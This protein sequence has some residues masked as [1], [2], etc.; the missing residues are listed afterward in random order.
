MHLL[1]HF[2][3]YRDITISRMGVI[4]HRTFKTLA[5]VLFLIGASSAFGWL[6][7]LLKVPAM[8]SETMISFSPNDAITMLMILVILLIL[9]MVM[10]MAPLILIATPILLPVATSIGMD[11]VHFG[12]VLM[13]ALVFGLFTPLDG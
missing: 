10:D 9:G 11:P 6:L 4:L 13:L 3:V 2:F 12:V 1:S 5:M 7:A 8:V